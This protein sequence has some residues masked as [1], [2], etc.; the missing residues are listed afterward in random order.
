MAETI[1]DNLGFEDQR[2]AKDVGSLAALGTGAA[3]GASSGGIVGALVGFGVTLTGI[4]ISESV[5]ALLNTRKGPNDNWVYIQTKNIP[6]KVCFGSYNAN[7]KL[8]WKTYWN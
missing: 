3:I 7:D 6:K 8:Y 1:F 2:V 5:G 4:T